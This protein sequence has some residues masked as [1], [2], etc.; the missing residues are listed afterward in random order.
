L[1]RDF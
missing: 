1:I